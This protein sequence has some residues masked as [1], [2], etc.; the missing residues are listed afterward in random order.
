VKGYIGSTFTDGFAEQMP[1][2]KAHAY[3]HDAGKITTLLDTHVADANARKA[4]AD[5]LIDLLSHYKPKETQT[6]LDIK[7][8]ARSEFET[9]LFL[10][11][12][13]KA[14]CGSLLTTLQTQCSLGKEQY[15]DTIHKAVD[16]LSQHRWDQNP[17]NQRKPNSN[18]RNSNNNNNR[19]SGNDNRNNRHRDQNS[20]R[21]NNNSSNES[22]PNSSS[23][24]APSFAQQGLVGN[25][26]PT[27]RPSAM[28]VARWA[29]STRIVT[30]IFP[31]TAGSSTEL[32]WPSRTLARTPLLLTSLPTRTMPR[33]AVDTPRDPP[34]LL[35]IAG[36]THPMTL[37]GRVSSSLTLWTKLTSL[38]LSVASP[39]PH[40]LPVSQM[41]FF[42]TLALAL[43]GL[44]VTQTLFETFAQPSDL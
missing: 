10:R 25:P 38:S 36:V 22:R 5:D 7:A 37:A 15:P 32:L 24:S 13:S 35:R 4:L 23:I 6:Q 18:S 40:R 1:E 33:L 31:E 26:S 30:R 44:S 3:K 43:T 12:V 9:Y 19:A 34:P 8:Q 2:H 42:W 41:S 29:T 39:R 21:S 17:F 14:K 16:I 11:S 28:P 20:S 27:P